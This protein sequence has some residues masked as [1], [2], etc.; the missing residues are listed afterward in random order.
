LSSFRSRPLL[1]ALAIVVFGTANLLVHVG[2]FRSPPAEDD[3]YNY[4]RDH[5]SNRG[6]RNNGDDPFRNGRIDDLEVRLREAENHILS[7]YNT[8][9][10]LENFEARLRDAEKRLGGPAAES[11]KARAGTQTATATT[12]TT[13]MVDDGRTKGGSPLSLSPPEDSRC[14]ADHPGFAATEKRCRPL[15]NN[16]HCWTHEREEEPTRPSTATTVGAVANNNA[17]PRCRRMLW[18]AGMYEGPPETTCRTDRYQRI[19]GAALNSAVDNASETIQPVLMLGRLNADRKLSR[20]GE[21]AASKGAKVLTVEKLSFQEV[22]D[23][24]YGDGPDNYRIGPWLRL[25]IPRLLREDPAFDDVPPECKTHVLYTDSDVIFPN[26][27]TADDTASLVDDLVA[28]NGAAAVSYGRESTKKRESRNTG[29]MVID[30][31]A[32]ERE[33]PNLIGSFD[34]RQ[35]TFDQTLINEHLP[36]ERKLVLPIHWNWKPYWRLSPSSIDEV[37][38]VHFHGPKPGGFGLEAIASCDPDDATTTPERIKEKYGI[39][40]D[41]GIC[42]DG[43]ATAAWALAAVDRWTPPASEVCDGGGGPTTNNPNEKKKKK[44]IGGGGGGDDEAVAD[45]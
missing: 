18:F 17:A 13:T 35:A 31:D 36:D 15:R 39:Y 23:E 4:D 27:I 9:S 40:I 16:G 11:A 42:C 2:R 41:Q 22:V 3:Y 44:R 20:F 14:H 25:D 12:T 33:I 32:F 10:R 28:S 24:H 8:G 1:V 7:I 6:N 19:Y 37:K 43:G 5:R 30:V 29:V 21:W 38:V 45:A 34:G 26:P